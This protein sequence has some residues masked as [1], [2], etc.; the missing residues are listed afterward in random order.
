M[1]D[2]VDERVIFVVRIRG[3]KI[4]FTYLFRIANLSDDMTKALHSLR[5]KEVNSGVFLRM[6]KKLAATLK[7]IEPY[8]T[9]G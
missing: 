2:E 8:V 5:L 1:T 9:Y 6:D 7:K 3:Y 4:N